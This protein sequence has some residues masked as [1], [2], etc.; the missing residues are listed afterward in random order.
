MHNSLIFIAFRLNA[1]CEHILRTYTGIYTFNLKWNEVATTEKNDGKSISLH[2]LQFIASNLHHLMM[3]R[4]L[5]SAK[6]IELKRRLQSNKMVFSS[7]NHKLKEHFR[8]RNFIRHSRQLDRIG[9][10]R[11]ELNWTERRKKWKKIPRICRGFMRKTN[12]KRIHFSKRV[13]GKVIRN[14]FHSML[15]YSSVR[16]LCWNWKWNAIHEWGYNG[17][18]FFL[19]SDALFN[20][21]SFI[22]L[23]R[24]CHS[25]NC[26]FSPSVNISQFDLSWPSSYRCQNC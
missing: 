22:G 7:K 15:W 1:Y 14:E 26:F 21:C 8:I 10:N 20:E 9:M 2:S 13:R 23:L 11:R 16:L 6:K 12:E 4:T 19:A 24:R 3:F 18:H 5:L 17:I 25:T